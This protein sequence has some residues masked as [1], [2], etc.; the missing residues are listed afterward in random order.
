ME[1]PTVTKSQRHVHGKWYADASGSA[2]AMELLGP[3]WSMLIVR[4][5][6]SGARRFTDLRG[7][8]PG[9]SAKV[10]T[11]RLGTL[12]EG[13]VI[14][15]RQLEAPARGQVYELTEWGRQAETAIQALTRWA[16]QSPD[17]NSK[18][19]LS[20]A[21]LMLELKAALDP[22]RTVGVDM[23]IGFGIGRDK[24]IAELQGGELLVQRGRFERAQ[25][26]FYADDAGPLADL[27]L[28][29]APLEELE[30]E[31]TIEISGKRDLAL[32]FVTFFAASADRD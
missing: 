6:L 18:L 17:L 7:D 10:L 20:T 22:L 11:E 12:E 24:Y 13:G 1:S 4:E 27:F 21:S 29:D 5:L 3:R 30:D 14:A 16:S 2:F 19:P 9:I 25:A 26:I 28:G 31:E 32:Q 8:L 23:R 15:R